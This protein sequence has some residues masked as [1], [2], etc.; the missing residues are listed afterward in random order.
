MGTFVA[1]GVCFDIA[2]GEGE[3]DGLGVGVELVP[4]TID[5]EP[6]RALNFSFPKP[7]LKM[8]VCATL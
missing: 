3:A 5:S 2:V 4:E 1:A 8:G 7:S 6:I